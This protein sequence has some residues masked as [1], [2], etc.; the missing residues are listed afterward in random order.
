MGIRIWITRSLTVQGFN[1]PLQGG[2]SKFYHLM[3]LSSHRLSARYLYRFGFL[4][5]TCDRLCN[6][7]RGLSI[8][9]AT[10]EGAWVFE[11]LKLLI[12]C[13]YLFNS[14]NIGY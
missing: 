12:V 6:R 4:K 5:N 8:I 14:F 7:R 2:A 1:T 10:G 11:G 3:L 13:Q 9:C